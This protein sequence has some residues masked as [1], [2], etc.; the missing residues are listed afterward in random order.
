M[1]LLPLFNNK[2]A[3][4]KFLVA[5]IDSDKLKV[6]AF[7]YEGNKD[8]KIIGS[9]I[10]S[11]KE[12]SI[13]NYHIL[14]KD[15]IA[16][17]LREAVMEATSELGETVKDIIIGVKGSQCIE[18][19]TT[20]KST[21][22]NR[23][24]IKEKDLSEI[25]NRITEASFIQA[26]NEVIQNTGIYDSK[27]ETITSSIV[28]TKLDDKLFENPVG[29]EGEIVESAVFNAFCFS[30][31]MKVIKKIVKKAGLR[32]LAIAPTPYALV[33]NITNMDMEEV[34]D[35]TLIN[36]GES[37]TEIAIVFGKGLVGT[38]TLPIGYTHLRNGM[39]Y[40]MG[41]TAREAEKVLDTYIQGQLTESE[42]AVVQKCL[43][44]ILEIWMEGMKVC[45]EDFTEIKTFASQIYLTGEGTKIPDVINVLKEA[46][47]YKNIPFKTL[48]EY[49]K[50]DIND[51]TSI[52]D[53]TGKID[54]PIWIPVQSLGIIYLEMQEQDD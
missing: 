26:Q 21:A 19:T 32:L 50:I 8:I 14:D 47:W 38:K 30:E 12:N 37:I 35:Y 20:A 29:C 41:L 52:G 54:S 42:E 46:P 39:G 11:L 1:S 34:T 5:E 23:R 36:F 49:K 10:K 2:K 15:A 31:D 33:Q 3:S 28:Y 9:S 7:Y 51:F 25:Y 4:N 22:T 48:P 45:F 18:I 16:L 44:D 43:N 53:A 6:L 27:I 24:V 40:K 17:S 13:V